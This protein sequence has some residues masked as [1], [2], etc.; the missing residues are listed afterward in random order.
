MFILLDYDLW[1]IPLLSPPM[2]LT[3]DGYAADA[4]ISQEHVGSRLCLELFL[5]PLPMMFHSEACDVLLSG[6]ICKS[7]TGTGML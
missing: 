6:L 5:D 3:V 2:F 4:A 7:C 1:S